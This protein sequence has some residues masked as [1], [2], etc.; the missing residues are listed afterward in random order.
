MV[1][2]VGAGGE[3]AAPAS[4]AYARYALAVLTGVAL[5]NF[6]DR[7]IIAI[8]A[9]PIKRD[10]GLTDSQVG[11]TAGLSFALLYTTLGIPVA[12]LADRWNR[13][14]IIA[15]AIAIWSA[16]TIVCGLAQ[17]FTQL[18]LARVG[19][20]VGE[21]GSGPASHSL[22]SDL[23]PPEERAGAFGWYGLGIPVGAF[24]A[25]AGGGW[26]VQNFSWREAFFLA[27]AP[28]LVIALLVAFTVKEPRI[29]AVKPQRGQS[30]GAALRELAAKPA[31]WNLAAAATLVAFVAYGFS[32]FYGAFFVRIH[33]MSYSEL[34]V[35]LGAMVGL[36]GAF[37]AWSGGWVADR[38][39]KKNVAATLWLPAIALIAAAPLF[40]W[41]LVIDDKWA[42]LALIAAPTFAATFYY[43]PTFATVQGLAKPQTRAMAVA[44]FIFISSLIGMGAG[45]V[46][47]GALSD[48][49][50]AAHMQAN[51]GASFKAACPAA[52]EACSA[53]EAAG[54]RRA[55]LILSLFNIWAAAH[56]WLAARTLKRDLNE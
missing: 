25:Y 29:G 19:V 43:G 38:F 22:L 50:T 44:I 3:A 33:G 21:A 4:E 37:G 56:F 17:N 34:G 11:L 52:G 30:V 48:M 5:I 51:A 23:F 32:S 9:E 55:I 12:W 42:A 41:G 1:Q 16:M 10:M 7:Q 18:F 45:P 54:I 20:G 39:H 27:G 53:A 49:F 13:P 26:I 24:I 2:A 31:Y 15:I 35:G 40:A 14:R 36:T 46:F 8:L 28:G 47:A 6:L